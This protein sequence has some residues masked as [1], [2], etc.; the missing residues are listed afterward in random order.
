[1]INVD[2]KGDKQ[3]DYN[4]IVQEILNIGEE[5]LKKRGRNISCGGQSVSHVQKLWICA[6]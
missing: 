1:M 5:L 4:L 2:K 6:K 3:M